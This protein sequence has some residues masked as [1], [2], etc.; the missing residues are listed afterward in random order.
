MLS[1]VPGKQYCLLLCRNSEGMQREGWDMTY[2]WYCSTQSNK[3]FM[4]IHLMQR[5]GLGGAIGE[6]KEEF[7]ACLVLG[8][9]SR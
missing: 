5:I 8:R 4:T 1:I 2:S 3:Y 7:C 9:E 6:N